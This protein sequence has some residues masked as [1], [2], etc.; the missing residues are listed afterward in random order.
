MRKKLTAPNGPSECAAMST[1]AHS[2]NRPT[3]AI[4]GSGQLAKMMAQAA[5][6]LGC[7][8]KVLE[9]RPN[10]APLADWE[11]TLGDWNDPAVLIPFAEGA[12]VV[13]L[14]NEFI[15]SDALAELEVSGRLLFPPAACLAQ[16]QDKLLQKEALAAANLPLAPFRPVSSP[17]EVV[18]AA[19]RW[20][21]PLVLKRRKLGYDGKGNATIRSAA[22]VAAAWQ[23][24]EGGAAA[25]Y[26]EQFCPFDREL[27]VM[28]TRA[29]PDVSDEVVVYPVVDTLQR[30][31]ICHTVTAPAR[32]PPE[33]MAAASLTAKRAVEAIG[34]VGSVGVELFLMSDGQILINEM[35][36][37]VHNSGHY[38]IEGCDCSQ[39][40]NHIRAI[41]GW[42]LGSPTLRAPAAAMVNLIGAGDGPAMPMGLRDALAV[43]GAQIHIYGKDRS[44]KGRKMGHVTALGPT[45]EKALAIAQRAAQRLRFG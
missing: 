39:F 7:R 1:P 41:L 35:A 28:V 30:D 45:P 44:M 36:P 17:D 13:T 15:E 43:E 12:D 6:Q 3:I 20:G 40:E 19:E 10:P 16:V 9:N 34:G 42:P 25:L 18:E 27:A 33:W 31:H 21:W 4:L 23:K 32:L 22:E 14:E 26:V 5:T 11:V 38:S 29:R 8:V 2:H 24:L 37:R